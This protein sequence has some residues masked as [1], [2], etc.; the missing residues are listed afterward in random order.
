MNAI[1]NT[2]ISAAEPPLSSLKAGLMRR[3]HEVLVFLRVFFT[4]VIIHLVWLVRLCLGLVQW[5]EAIGIRTKKSVVR[6]LMYRGGYF[7]QTPRLGLTA[8]L[9]TTVFSMLAFPAVGT[10]T[11][12]R[13]LAL[14]TSGANTMFVPSGLVVLAAG[15]SSPVMA[16]SD[17]GTRN[18]SDE[19]V[20]RPGDTLGTIA[21]E[22]LVSTEAIKYVNSIRGDLIRPGDVITIPPVNGLIHTVGESETVSSIA[23]LYSASPQAIVDFNHI[24]EPYVIHKGDRIT[25]PDAKVPA[26]V[27]LVAAPPASN[28][29]G[30]VLQTIGNPQ[31]GT[32]AFTMPTA[33]VLTQYFWWGHTAVDIAAS[34][35]TPIIAA[36][37]GN[38]T[39]A[40]WWAGGGGNSIFIDHNNGY[41]TKYAH[42]SGFARTS[43]FV[44]Q[45]EVIGYM[46][47]TGRA[48]G[49]HIHFIVD[50]GGRP[51]DPLSVL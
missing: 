35:G 4:R 21:E 22:Y 25:V 24:E 49:C 10:L 3:L 46:G 37:S 38:I 5:V 17:A 20:V 48:Y 23:R 34:C 50:H 43:G 12:Q 19:Y 16:Q 26:P 32:G 9:S 39:F 2:G 11:Q 41:V 51:I 6:I 7:Y 8:V 47:D 18:K 31:P 40:G 33:G 42:M 44:Q 45:G 14:V 15:V 27:A 30:L 36:D 29:A 28:G 1:M 13:A